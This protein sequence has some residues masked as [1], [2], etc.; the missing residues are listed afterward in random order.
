MKVVIDN[1]TK[2]V[3]G[4]WRGDVTEFHG[5]PLDPPQFRVELKQ[6]LMLDAAERFT[7]VS[8]LDAHVEDAA[9][10]FCDFCDVLRPWDEMLK[11][12]STRPSDP[13]SACSVMWGCTT[14]GNGK[15]DAE[16]EAEFEAQG[17]AWEG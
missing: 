6:G 11:L 15:P 13:W 12:A 7:H 3:L 16:L 10:F 8:Q 5:L 4:A 17:I 1:A 14:C 9:F 2:A